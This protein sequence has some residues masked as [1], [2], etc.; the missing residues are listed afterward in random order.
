METYAELML[1]FETPLTSPGVTYKKKKLVINGK[2]MTAVE[3]FC[4]NSCLILDALFN[5]VRTELED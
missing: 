4:Y 1:R 5:L 2:P 3:L